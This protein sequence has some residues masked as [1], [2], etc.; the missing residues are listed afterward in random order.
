M[1]ES[2]KQQAISDIKESLTLQGKCFLAF[3]AELD[4]VMEKL[5]EEESKKQLIASIL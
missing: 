1:A 3:R 4:P 2:A 5:V